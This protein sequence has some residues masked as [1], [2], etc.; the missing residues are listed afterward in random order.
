MNSWIQPSPRRV[1]G[2]PA[3]IRARALRDLKAL[4]RDEAPQPLPGDRLIAPPAL[5]PCQLRLREGEWKWT[6]KY[7][8]ANRYIRRAVTLPTLP[9][10]QVDTTYS[11]PT[12]TT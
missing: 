10:S 3:I 4:M 7:Q 11:L 6:P 2:P 1:I 5:I 12:G 9:Q 8:K